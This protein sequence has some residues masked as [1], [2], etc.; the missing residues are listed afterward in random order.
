MNNLARTAVGLAAVGRP[1]YINLGRDAL[2]A[3]RTVEAMRA[4]TFDVL[5][6]AYTAGVRR[7]DAARS[8]GRAEEFLA[9]W[10]AERGHDDVV[11]S[12]KWGYAYVGDWRMDASVHEEKEHSLE[13]FRRQWAETQATV[14][15]PALYQVHSLTVDS[16]LLTDTAL[17]EALAELVDAGVRV[18]FSTSGPAQADTI[19]R[20]FDLTVDG[21]QLFTA[22]QSTWNVLEQSA[23]LALAEAHKAGA[24]VQLKETLANGRLAIEA[25]ESVAAVARGRQV[26]ADAVALA[27]AYAQPWADVVL[28]GPAGTDQLAANLAATELDLTDDDLE[29]LA[30][31]REKPGDYW[32]RRSQLG[33]G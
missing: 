21:R 27:A 16:P 12:S 15:V 23:G 22:V 5:D 14:G 28:V 7:V 2:P 29:I 26:S 4:I 30:E 33:W 11:V 17:Q 32:A 8:Y 20:A 13:R 9:A 24:L 25:P 1:A 10:L 31:L 3:D 6:A 19:R 18:G